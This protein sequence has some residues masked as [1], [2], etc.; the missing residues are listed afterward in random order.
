MAITEIRMPLLGVNDDKVILHKWN[1]ERGEKVNVGDELAQLETTKASFAL[2]AEASGYLYPIVEN[3]SEVPVRSVLAFLLD[4]PDEDAVGA[5]RARLRQAPADEKG[6]PA[7]T[8]ALRDLQLTVKA[9][10]LVEKAGVDISMLPADRVVR[11]RDVLELLAKQPV[12]PLREP[13]L[14]RDQAR[15]VAVYGASLAGHTVVDAIRAMGGYEVVAFMDDTPG[16]IGGSVFGLPVWS[17]NELETLTARGIGAVATHIAVREFRLTM[18]DRASAAGLTMLNVIHPRA[19][20]SPSVQMGVGNLIKAGAIVD[21]EVQLGDCCIIDDG[22]IVSH[23]NVIHDA[24]HLAPG[25]AMGGECSLGER[26]LVGI[27]SKIASRIRIGRNVIVRP[28]SVVV[29]DV[30]DDVLVGGN[31]AKVAGKRR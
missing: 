13:A 10:E 11:E 26:T 5:L 24:C 3:G 7:G 25:V 19:F 29:N 31:P 16:L 21:T 18:R 23:H 9:R 12:V 20:V 1:V 27:G 6:A 22:V 8:I 30:P 14:H 28:G 17:G 15:R 2:E 4:R